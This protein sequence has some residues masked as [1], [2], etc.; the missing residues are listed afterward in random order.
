VDLP[1]SAIVDGAALSV[2]IGE[3]EMTMILV[4]PD[5]DPVEP[6]HVSV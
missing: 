6:V 4:D 1:P 3:E 2:A 5:P